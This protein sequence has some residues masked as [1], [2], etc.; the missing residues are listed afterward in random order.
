MNRK[1][2]IKA[3]KMLNDEEGLL[4]RINREKIVSTGKGRTTDILAAEFKVT[5]LALEDAKLLDE[6][7]PMTYEFYNNNADEFVSDPEAVEEVVEE[8]EEVVEETEEGVE[9]TEKPEKKQYSRAQA[10]CD[11]LSGKAKTLTNIAEISM[12]LYADNNP[13]RK[14]R[15]LESVEWDIRKSYIQPLVILGFVELKDKKYSLK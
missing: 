12:K 1:E 3:I 10:F 4:E 2:L 7:P 9:E 5:M 15:K 13:G 6:A 11:A 8:V 14:V